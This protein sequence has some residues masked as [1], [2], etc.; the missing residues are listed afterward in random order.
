MK[1]TL[2]PRGFT[3][4]EVLIVMLVLVTVGSIILSI[5]VIALTGAAKTRNQQIVRENGNFAI[6]QITRQIQYAKGFNYVQI[7]SDVSGTRLL[8]CTEGADTEFSAVSVVSFDES[9][10]IFACMNIPDTD[11]MTIASQGASLINVN[12]V[13]VKECYFT[14]QQSTLA[15]SP[16]IGVYMELAPINSKTNP[17]IFD[18]SIVPR[19]F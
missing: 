3:L 6:S 14:C 17:I 19:N 2:S 4:I 10:T 16:T 15:E 8:E 11:S 12:K 18:A 7:G 5:F 1:M 9:D 13:E